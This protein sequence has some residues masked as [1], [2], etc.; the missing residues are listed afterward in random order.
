VGADL[1]LRG[2]TGYPFDVDLSR[3]YPRYNP[4]EFSVTELLARGDV[5][6]ALVLGTAPG[7]EVTGQMAE[8][9]ARIP[10][11]LLSPAACGGSFARVRVTTAP[12]GLST[13]GL[14]SRM[15]DLPLTLTPALPSPYPAED[16][17]LRRIN[18]AIAP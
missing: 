10:T 13:S 12:F 18:A 1:L 7:A 17:V 9:L 16:E 5:D 3:G 8:A 4:G 6:A 2:T 14:V 15:D 11:V